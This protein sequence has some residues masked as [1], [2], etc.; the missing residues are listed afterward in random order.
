MN[1]YYAMVT[2]NQDE[3][4]WTSILNCQRFART[5]VKDGLGL[6]WADIDMAT[7]N[8]PIIMDIGT[9]CLSVTQNTK[10]ALRDRK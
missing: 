10:S 5:F 2:E 9:V 3:E 8:L 1:I 6:V 4:R 7:N